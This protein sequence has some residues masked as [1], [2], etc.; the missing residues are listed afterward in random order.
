MMEIQQMSTHYEVKRLSEENIPEI[1]RLCQ[2][3][4]SYYELCPPLVDETSIK[5]DMQAL[6]PN[7]TQEEK[8]YIGFYHH[9]GLAAL[10]DWI[11]G[12]P[13]EKTVFIGFFMLERTMQG[14]GMGSAIITE[15]CDYFKTLRFQKIQ[16]GVIQGNQ[17]AVQF[18]QKNQFLIKGEKRVQQYDAVILMERTIAENC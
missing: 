2:G 3:N 17:A 16:L 10:M 11:S 15:C 8:N 7:K 18:W 1:L 13:E 12:Y 5:A 6:P 4:R 9:Q 14:Q